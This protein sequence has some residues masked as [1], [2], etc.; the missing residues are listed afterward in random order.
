MKKYDQTDKD[1]LKAEE[2]L[3]PSSNDVYPVSQE[4]SHEHQKTIS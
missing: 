2:G 4:E 1:V 3:D